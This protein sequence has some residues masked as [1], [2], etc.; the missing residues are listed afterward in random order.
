MRQGRKGL[1]QLPWNGWEAVQT[2][3]V[4]EQAAHQL[5]VYGKADPG[6]VISAAKAD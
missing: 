4:S 3:R 1:L 6:K 5:P 2:Q